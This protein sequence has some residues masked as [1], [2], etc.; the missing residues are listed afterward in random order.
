MGIDTTGRVAIEKALNSVSRR[1]RA[2]TLGRQTI[3]GTSEY[4][5]SLFTQEFQFETIDSID[6]SSYEGASI[7]HNM[8]MPYTSNCTYDFIFDGG[9]TEHIFNVPQVL[10]NVI[11]LL[12]TDGI[13]CSVTPNN[14][15][16][17]HGFYQFSPDVFHSC[18]TL[19]YGMK[20]LGVWLAI[21][22]DDHTPWMDMYTEKHTND[23]QGFDT[24]KGVYI[25][26]IAQKVS[27]AR[28][29]LIEDPP[30][31]QCYEKNFWM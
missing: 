7:I 31:Q 10:E 15:F 25:I 2:L 17:G 6:Y 11:N 13:Y 21:A 5:E 8:N 22:N 14:N 9:T 27:G 30:C 24:H 12:D 3:C 18:F 29:S 28:A 26:C 1:T 16:S 4:C 20:L 19:K 23:I